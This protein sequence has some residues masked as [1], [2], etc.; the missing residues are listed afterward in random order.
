MASHLTSKIAFS[1]QPLPSAFSQPNRCRRV[2]SSF[3]RMSSSTTIEHVVLFKIKPQTTPSKLS[4]MLNGL[5]SLK[6]LNQV[7]HLTAGPIYNTTT[8]F[9]HILHSRYSSKSDL[10]TYASHPDH[11]SVVR[12][13]VIPICDD[14]MAVDWISNSPSLQPIIPPSK[15]AM[16]ITFLKLK[17]GLP[18][19]DKSEAVKAAKKTFGKVEQSSIGE[20]F[21]P[22][23]AKGFSMAADLREVAAA[24]DLRTS[25]RLRRRWLGLG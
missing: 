23:R 20:N 13:S 2:P 18:E 25:A 4:A 17:N 9:T 3:I 1:Y 10:S 21:S 22:E 15:Y 12:E 6:S 24:A 16:R 5:N 19:S 14:L 7:L 11:I 8:D